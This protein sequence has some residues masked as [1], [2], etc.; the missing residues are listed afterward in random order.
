MW[1]AVLW[2][3]HRKCYD[4]LQRWLLE[5]M[6]G[7]HWKAGRLSERH[8]ILAAH[9]I[10]GNRGCRGGAQNSWTIVV[11]RNLGARLMENVQATNHQSKFGW[12]PQ[13]SLICHF[14]LNTTSFQPSYYQRIGWESLGTLGRVSKVKKALEDGENFQGKRAGCGGNWFSR[15][16]FAGKP[17]YLMG[18]TWKS[19]D[20]TAVMGNLYVCSPE[21]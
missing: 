9:Y 21:I 17:Q 12:L 11:S 4:P 6:A 19:G 8:C 2:L 7:D 13:L 1:A 20:F 10:V 15:V 5:E 14:S 16:H 3:D 18:N